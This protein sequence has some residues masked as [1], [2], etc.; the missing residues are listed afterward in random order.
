MKRISITRGKRVLAAWLAV[1]MA[2]TT[3]APVGPYTA[4]AAG[5]FYGYCVD[6]AA[7]GSPRPCKNDSDQYGLVAP[8]AMFTAEEK[9]IV[10]WATLS[11]LASRNASK[12]ISTAI[13]NIKNQAPEEFKSIYRPVTEAEL[14]GVLHS[15]AI[16]AKY[17]WLNVVLANQEQYL[18][19]PG[20]MGGSGG[21]TVGGG[22]IPTVLQ[23]HTKKETALEI[24]AVDGQKNSFTISFD[25]SGADADF[26][27]KVPLKFSLTGDPDSF[28]PEPMGGWTYQKTATSITFSNPNPEP[29]K[30]L[31]IFD[32]TGTPYESGET[33]ASPEEVYETCLKAY[34]CTACSGTHKTTHFKGAVALERHQ[35]LVNIEIKPNPKIFYAA[36]AGD[37]VITD[38]GGIKFV[39]YHHEED[40]TSTYN[41]Q[42]YK[43]DHETGKPLEGATF[44][45]YERFDDKNKI[46]K[47]R[48]GAAEIYEGGEPY[49][50]YHTDDPVT[51]NDFRLVTTA[52]TDKN[53]H[54]KKSINHGYHYDKT[55]CDGHPAPD[56][57]DVPEEEEDEETGEVINEGEIEEAQ[58]KNRQLAQRWLDCY[59]ACEDQAR[60]EFSGVHFH[61]LMDSVDKGEIES[62][63]NSGGSPGETPEAGTTESADGDA[64]FDKSGC[65][66]DAQET[67]DKFVSL[68]YSYTFREEK[69]R[70]GYTL[71]GNHADDLPI[72]VITTDASENGANA[73]FAGEYSD[74]ITV[75]SVTSS[76]EDEDRTRAAQTYRLSPAPNTE[77]A[78]L[79]KEPESVKQKVLSFSPADAADTA[80]TETDEVELFN[81]LEGER[82][83]TPAD[84]D[85]SGDGNTATPGNAE[86]TATPSDAEE[87]ATPGETSTVR[88]VT[89]LAFSKTPAADGLLAQSGSEDE[90]EEDGET[91]GGN[92]AIF[93]SAYN[94]AYSKESSGDGVE[95]G[96]SGKYSHCNDAD[97]EGN[98]WRIYDHR[99]EGEIHINKRDMELKAGESESYDSYGDTQGD[100]TLEGAVYGLFAAKDIIHPDGKTKAVYKANNLV[101]VA[102]TDK[103]GDASFMV[104]TEAP[105][106]TYDYEK[107]A[108][109]KTADN[110]AD[111]APGN[112]Y[113]ADI[114]YDDYTA[115]GQY[116]RRYYDNAAKNGHSFIGRP[117]LLGDYYIKELSRSEGYE[118]SI[119]NKGKA[120]TNK[121]QDV[122]VS[123]AEDGDGYA[124]ISRAMFAEEQIS[125]APTGAY[126]D[127]DYNEIFFEAE[128][129][130]TGAEGF[131]LCFENLPDGT[132]LYRLD[133]SMEEREIEVGTGVFDEIPVTDG[134][135]NPVYVTAEND[136]QYP[137]YNADGTLMTREVPVNTSVRNAPFELRQPLDAA[138]AQEALLAEEPGMAADAVLPKLTAEFSI[139][140]K[141]FVKG[142]LERA[143]RASGKI[144]PYTTSGGTKDYSNIY[145]GVYDAGVRE[146]DID[147]YGVAGGA[148]GSIAAKT[149]YGSPVIEV[150]VPKVNQSGTP[151][152]TGDVLA[153]LLDFYN[154]N[155]MYSYG[156][157][158]S[159]EETADSFVFT[160]YAGRYG[161]PSDFFVPDD[162]GNEGT[163]YKRVEYIPDDAGKC[164][165][166]IYADYTP[167]ASGAFGTYRDPSVREI[168]G[169]RY[170][171]AVLVTDAVS[172]GSGRL[173]TKTRQEN[174]YYLT[175]ETPYDKDGNPI[176]KVEYRE[177]TTTATQEVPVGQY[178]E[179]PLERRDGAQLAHI[180]SS[181][182]DSYGA[183]H[184]DGETQYYTFKLVLPKKEITLTA[185]D[186]E[187]L[188]EESGFAAGDTMGSAAYYLS[189]KFANV[190][191]YLDYDKRA[192]GGA[193]SFVKEAS[194]TYPGQSYTWQDG[195]GKPGTGTV[196]APV[197]VEER[198]IRQ[199]VK[200]TK[201]IDEKSY[202]NT[203]SYAA[204]HED[205]W[206]RMFGGF[207]GTK[208]A[209]KMPG[210]RF[211]TYL[212]SNLERLYRDESGA[213][214]WQDKNG[215]EYAGNDAGL[216]AA[217]RKFPALAETVYTKALHKT[218]PLR[219]DPRD[220]VTAN[221]A[222]YSYT[223]GLI[224]AEQN[225]GYTAVL[226][227]VMRKAEDGAGTRLVTA[228]NYDKFFDALA[229]ANNDKWD[230]AAPTY[231]SHQPIGNAP[232][233]TQAAL[234]N[235]SASD[236]VRQFA[237]DWYLDDEVAKLVKP[238]S[239]TSGDTQ[240]ADESVA[241]S[242]ELYDEALQA[243]I[244]KAEN[245]LKPFFAY[246]LDTI[247]AIECDGEE[248]GGAD[249]DKSTL[250]AD[251]LREGS[252]ADESGYCYGVSAYLPYGTYV[253]VEQQ[254]QYAELE[255]FKNKH[256]EID[257]PREVELPAVYDSYAGSQSS[258]EVMNGYYA[259]RA[260]MAQDEMERKFMIRFSEES[261]IIYAH[262]R[263]GDFEVYKYGMDLD[264][265]TNGVPAAPGAG[266]HFALTQSEYRPD[267]N[268]YN[269]SGKRSADGNAY[270]LTE[271]QSGRTGI[272]ARYRY[273]SVSEDAGTADDVAYP[274]GTVTEDNKP[275][276][277]Y[278]DNV[279]TMQGVGRAFDGRYAPMLVPYTVTAPQ[280]AATES[281]Q[282]AP[283]GSGEA[284]YVGYGYTKFMDRL[285]TAKLR[286]EKLDSETHE[287]ILHD[288]VL[289]SIYAAKRDDSRDGDGKVLFYEEDTT[290]SGTKEFL[291]AMG[292]KDIRPMA[293]TRNMFDRLRSFLTG[294]NAGP[295]TRYTGLVPAGTPVCAESEQ[296]VLGDPYGKQTVAFR[297]YSTVRDG[298]MKNEDGTG[299]G[300]ELQTVGYLE[301]PQPL[302]AG[303]YVLCEMKAPSGYVRTKPVAVEIYSDKVTYYKEGNKDSRI[304]A[305]LYA[306]ASDNLTANG[307]KPQDQVNVARVNVENAPITLKVEKLKESSADTANT[308][309]DKTVSYKVS[310]RVEG[311]LLQIGNNPDLVYA[312]ENGRYL[313][314][315]WK[316]GTLEYL[317]AR[318]AAG[319]DVEIVYNGS[320]FAGYGYVTRSLE[321]ADDANRYVAGATMTL[322]EALKLTPS[323]DSE[324]H[325]YEGLVIERSIAGNVTRMYVKEGY[326]G[327]TVEFIKETDEDGNEITTTYQ[328]GAYKDGDPIMAEGNVWNAVTVKRG[329]TDILY[330]DLDSLTVTE[331]A[332]VDGE[333]VV[334]GYDR[335][336]NRVPIYQAEA[337][338]A[339]HRKTD[340]GHTIFA[341][342][343]GTPY[344]EFEGGDF[345]KI[346]YSARDK[347]LTVGEGTKVYHLDRDGN[348]DALVDPY[349][350]MAYVEAPEKDTGRT[351][352]AT[353]GNGNTENVLV[354]PVTIHKDEH[355]NVTARDKRTT[356]RVAT[357]GENREISGE[358][359]YMTG[360]WRSAAG[361]E[362]HKKS[363]VQLNRDSQ[364]M[365]GE[366]LTADNNGTFE[367]T[368]NPAV[369]AHGL[370][371]YYQK[372]GETYDKAEDL[373][374][375]NG[376]FVRQ[377][378]SDELAAYNDAAYRVNAADEL[379]DGDETKKAQERSKLYHRLGEGYILENTWV[380][381]DRTPN[382]PFDT[383]ATDGQAD[384]L[385]RVPAG[386]YILE[387][388]KSPAGYLKAMPSGVTVKE[389]A[390]VQPAA[391]TDKTVKAEI[392]KTDA[393]ESLTRKVI[394]R[395]SGDKVIGS[396]EEAASAFSYGAVEGA[397]VALYEA[398]KVYTDDYG[399]YPKGYYLKKTGAEPV[400]YLSTDSRASEKMELAASWV[401]GERPAYLEGIPEGSYLLEE[402]FTPA[403]F[404][405][406]KPLE[407]EIRNTP[408][409]QTFIMADDHTRVEVE[410]YAWNEDETRTELVGGA[411][412]T[413]YKAVTDTD[414]SIVYADGKPQYDVGAKVAEWTSSDALAYRDFPVAFEAMYREYGTAPG[415]S[416]SWDADGVRRTASYVS[417]E[418]LDASLTGGRGS[419]FPTAAVMT[420]KTDEG[421]EIR[422]GVYGENEN[423][424]G[425]DFT[426]EYR[427]EYRELPGITPHAATWLTGQG[428][429]RLEYLPAGGRYVLVETRAP[430]GYAGAED[431]AVEVLD[432]A[433]V[434]RYRVKNEEGRL[435]ISK[436]AKGSSGEL[437]GARL[438]LYRADASGGLTRTEEYVKERFVSGEDGVYTEL[439]FVNG[440]IPDGY[441]RGD[442]K[443]HTAG[444]LSD[445]VYWLVEEQS[446]AYYTTFEPVRIEYRQAD[447]LRIER[448]TDEAAVGELTVKK[449]DP[450]GKKLSGAVFTLSAYRKG[451]PGTPVF[452]REISV[453]DGAAAVKELPVGEAGEHGRIE[454]YTYELRE[455]TPPEGYGLNPEIVKWEFAPDKDGVSYTYGETAK[456]EVTVVDEPVTRTDPDPDPKQDP[457]PD[458]KPE[459]PPETNPGKPE[460]PGGHDEPEIETPQIPLVP[461]LCRVGFVTARYK[462]ETS[463]IRGR[464]YLDADGKIR[465]PLPR[466]GDYEDEAR[467]LWGF[468]AALAG[469]FLMRK[470]KKKA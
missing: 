358:S 165:R 169:T 20:L 469:A 359:G 222:L 96:P 108:V 173:I 375:R 417:C 242:D 265:I 330:Y 304:L 52:T 307:T 267:K 277:Y 116:E 360:S 389:T 292:A 115:D 266:D 340:S 247:Y 420:F 424:S 401:T 55:F 167:S 396:E 8:S 10:F 16:R 223:D 101:A 296:I 121:G 79:E 103:N 29:P 45:L 141:N 77:T 97:G 470:R 14:K 280:S 419:V 156:G 239:G 113:T 394:D 376:D 283:S 306:D 202:N 462:P 91:G 416:V 127:P 44:N 209:D 427:Y 379:H 453:T 2:F 332:R 364:S 207:D 421:K 295:G 64:A 218:D 404:V 231:T 314:Y 12:E 138:K 57:V 153:S 355:G 135:G 56:F 252:D 449:T 308:T 369:N 211:K 229:V 225:P 1:V 66:A 19:M 90:D 158:D 323:G 413:L 281:A 107:G 117:L 73:R 271:G 37:P 403:G 313:G 357:I 270:Y 254:P 439:D 253:I 200:V 383:E 377:Q 368:M 49:K 235:A 346:S 185:D 61:W 25:P 316:K 139:A 363:T 386:H 248:D 53:G 47:S 327:E 4:K 256:Y 362:S 24:A 448:V 328:T 166:Y 87:T 88:P 41:V 279:K 251:A 284:S 184:E 6:G 230:N 351:G 178:T 406:A 464:L 180:E 70:E 111:S 395:L 291:T 378:D 459:T 190:K 456:K 257:R 150:S 278:K 321:T 348:R 465:L 100:S 76:A 174:V 171:T 445:G 344:L 48:D 260:D 382:D 189:V 259:Y 305:A 347:S 329:D 258:P 322:F 400:R 198:P 411:G 361:E 334:Y 339:N 161:N 109:V 431:V 187:L 214:T 38:D 164:P 326:A 298:M 162:S 126:N 81:D 33:F 89:F 154:T 324:D 179:L 303:A 59:A 349:T 152:T 388:L 147:P 408:D 299:E 92:G 290:I 285:Y 457:R 192:V 28:V 72:E 62:V 105:G 402:L 415:T 440:R 183:A 104:C 3:L 85:V 98:A 124:G 391:M 15:A 195:T 262:G 84:A 18:Q 312:Y 409:V 237:I 131:D 273:S 263:D 136:Y 315:A 21:A 58:E 83:A 342:K 232:N 367:K 443:P 264:R 331:R 249:H 140:D 145:V 199:K 366:V 22:M 370:T 429:Q 241:Y 428:R 325:A 302:S 74:A 392:A 246:D 282:S 35:R 261:H 398:K 94:T 182:T 442:L 130:G 333:T 276:I 245:Y 243:A 414:G 381:S 63:G 176:Q 7:Y 42:L 142:K 436:Q 399:K 455:V 288:G 36:L 268:Y 128:S 365:N 444:K 447:G 217:K 160:V 65:K 177:Q 132:K 236:A 112:L 301:T 125:D 372:S 219:K 110:W 345:T 294:D 460:K 343:G 244:K 34:T 137:K 422:I 405:T 286:I 123:A 80:A 269:E 216:L 27:A 86:Q 350:G 310:G 46:N 71:H 410:K 354:W 337:D 250:S 175:G 418:A 468:F 435:L 151:V 233:R 407:V 293:R 425:R 300:Y 393:S 434:Q 255:D 412:F 194:L 43:Y 397:K 119:G 215:E 458:S 143:L 463:Q 433:D 437:A 385:K 319:E 311:N 461:P 11:M 238:V 423:L 144:T 275:G 338:K 318:K 289:F 320:V 196:K 208:A 146:G 430:E 441:A 205:W 188:G 204:V 50:S 426:F 317:A 227:T 170:F 380:T 228:Y 17:R 438:A 157:I 206:T 287:N 432:T 30:L 155:S 353:G 133:T 168:G 82:T 69:A 23:N 226:E 309:A 181:Y 352:A 272:S 224:N 31:V 129:K 134:D 26:I 13:E 191:A 452:T 467:Y 203:S 335:E 163:A 450:E 446:P 341:F 78:Y 297:A 213:V 9:A 336:S 454:A 201:K 466:T 221:T 32:P 99:I 373:Y 75:R 374:D 60:G 149:V 387:E 371:R 451:D 5:Q 159:I 197:G 68:K 212:R 54:A 274:G 93:E 384:V 114:A 67:Y 356:S 51:W 186:L 220:A 102:A 39:V 210:F 40:F 390:E 172:D 193:G 118:L 95:E 106:Y 240:A 148:P 120:L 234:E 122:N